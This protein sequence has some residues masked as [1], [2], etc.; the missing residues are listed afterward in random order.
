MLKVK[1]WTRAISILL[2]MLDT[3][4]VSIGL[5]V[6]EALGV[7]FE[8]GY[9]EK[10]VT[11]TQDCDDSLHE[12]TNNFE[13]EFST[14]EELKEYIIDR[15]KNIL[16]KPEAEE[17]PNK[18]AIES[19]L[20]LLEE[21]C[22]PETPVKIGKSKLTLNRWSELLQLNFVKR[23]LGNGFVSH[24]L[25]NEHLHGVFNF[26]VKGKTDDLYVAEREDVII[27]RFVPEVRRP[28]YRNLDG[29]K[30]NKAPSSIHSKATT[31]LL[32]KHRAA[33]ET[34]SSSFCEAM[35]D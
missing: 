24:M 12:E 11:I 33:K 35:D 4:D 9:L 18:Q 10:F 21:D 30:S 27:R 26:T 3:D 25:G 16:S 17:L 23:L 32:N 6:T 8:M 13:N 28:N 2:S 19:C 34:E 7:M 22:F 15:V 1:Y 31:Q 29:K 14:M 5:A 20:E